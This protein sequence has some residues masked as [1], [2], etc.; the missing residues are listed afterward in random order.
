MDGGAWNVSL[1]GGQFLADRTPGKRP[2]RRR[3]RRT[4][5]RR[6]YR[7]KRILLAEDEPI[8][9]QLA[10]RLL[11]DIG[12]SVDIAADGAQAVRMVEQGD[13]DLILMDMQMP[14]MDGLEATRAIRHLP[15]RSALPILAM[16]ANAFADDREKCIAVG[17]NDF[18]RK[19]VEPDVLFRIWLK[20]LALADN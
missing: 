15:G 6:G 17:M 4:V 3:S 18:T 19:P 5:L 13:D 20:W 9:Q 11:E 7:G 8:K 14:E 12:L 16:T 1:I 10:R 2:D